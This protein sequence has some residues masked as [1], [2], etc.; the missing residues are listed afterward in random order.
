MDTYI[1]N[2]I[3]SAMRDL[4]ETLIDLDDFAIECKIRKS[5]DELQS[6]LND[7]NARCTEEENYERPCDNCFEGYTDFD[8]AIYNIS[9]AIS[10]LREK[11][12]ILVKNLFPHYTKGN[13]LRVDEYRSILEKILETL[14]SYKN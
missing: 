1:I 7:M 12:R 3:Y 11:R 14:N 6:I 10:L 13:E 5:C 9:E 2:Y 4:E 8:F